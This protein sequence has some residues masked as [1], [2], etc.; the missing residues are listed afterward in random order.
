MIIS[1]ITRQSLKTSSS[2]ENRDHYVYLLISIYINVAPPEQLNQRWINFFCTDDRFQPINNN[3]EKENKAV[4]SRWMSYVVHRGIN[5][6][7]QACQVLSI[8]AWVN[9]VPLLN[10]IV[11][12]DSGSHQHLLLPSPLSLIHALISWLGSNGACLTCRV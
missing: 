6:S 10:C 1:S 11:P 2:I 8:V 7:T 3:A 9:C 5:G 12:G 4:V